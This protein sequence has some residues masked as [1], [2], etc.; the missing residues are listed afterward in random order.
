M[1]GT[2]RL[3][4]ASASGVMRIGD[5]GGGRW[6]QGQQEGG[7]GGGRDGEAPGGAAAPADLEAFSDPDFHRFSDSIFDLILEAKWSPNGAQKPHFW[8][9]LAP[10]I[11]NK[12]GVVSGRRKSRP[13]EPK[14]RDLEPSNSHF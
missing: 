13:Q 6:W 3:S 5:S 9:L 8:Q 14:Y 2:R 11:D 7:N 4:S 10:N 12:I 1:W